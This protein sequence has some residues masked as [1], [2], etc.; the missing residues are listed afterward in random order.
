MPR[1]SKFSFVA[2]SNL[3]TPSTVEYGNYVRVYPS[4]TMHFPKSTLFNLGIESGNFFISLFEDIEKRALAFRFTE[5]CDFPIPRNTKKFY[6]HSVAKG[7]GLVGVVS[8]GRFL[9]HIGGVEKSHRCDIKE[10]QDGMLGE[11]LYYIVIEK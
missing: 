5:N 7:N 1:S 2:L 10:Y 8:V 11:K 3:R 6:V 9:K 4:G